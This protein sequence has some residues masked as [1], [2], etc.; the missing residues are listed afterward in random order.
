MIRL[1]SSQSLLEDPNNQEINFLR[2]SSE[3]SLDSKPSESTRQKPPVMFGLGDTKSTTPDLRPHSPGSISPSRLVTALLLPLSFLARTSGL[4]SFGNLA[5]PVI[6]CECI[7]TTSNL[8]R[9]ESCDWPNRADN[10]TELP[11]HTQ[12]R[13]CVI[14]VYLKISESFVSRI[15]FNTSG[16]SSPSNS[17]RPDSCSTN[18]T[19]LSEKVVLLEKKRA[20][21][22]GNSFYSHIVQTMSPRFNIC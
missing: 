17:S 8:R 18:C 14:C 1:S 22:V 4:F 13:F 16:R 5:I 9:P 10:F 19:R 11:Y 15:G 7:C 12:S 2:S 21:E 3:S 6:Y 20:Y